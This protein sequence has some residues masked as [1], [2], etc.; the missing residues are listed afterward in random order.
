VRLPHCF[1]QKERLSEMV[2]IDALATSVR[3]AYCTTSR[4]TSVASCCS[5][6]QRL[7]FGDELI[8]LLHCVAGQPLQ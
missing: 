4:S 6:W 5:R 7:Q 3:F 8:D 2:C 1:P